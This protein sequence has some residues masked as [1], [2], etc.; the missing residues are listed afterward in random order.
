MLGISKMSLMSAE[1]YSNTT[2]ITHS[3]RMGDNSGIM[4]D[5]RVSVLSSSTLKPL[6]NRNSK[7]R[8]RGWQSPAGRG[9]AAAGALH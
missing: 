9:S 6:S 4:V 7:N 8:F 1:P 3:F 5:S 2:R